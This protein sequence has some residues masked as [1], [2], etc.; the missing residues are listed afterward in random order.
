MASS[1]NCKLK[2]TRAKLSSTSAF[3]G[4]TASARRKH[5]IDCSA[6]PL[7]RQKLPIWLYNCTDLGFSRLAFFSR[8][9][10]AS[11]SNDFC[12]CESFL[13]NM[14]DTSGSGTCGCVNRCA[15]PATMTVRKTRQSVSGNDDDVIMTTTYQQPRQC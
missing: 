1:R 4:D 10:S 11:M 5:S 7:M 15:T 6:S 2:S 13:K 8:R 12:V 9:S 14:Y 3:F